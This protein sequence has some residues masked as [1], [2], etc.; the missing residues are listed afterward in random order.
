MATFQA[1]IEW[2]LQH[3]GGF[4]KAA[5]DPGNYYQGQLIGTNWGVSAPVAR[6]AGWTGRMEDM[7]RQWAIDNVYLPNYWP[8]LSAINNE[9]IA[10]KILDMRLSGKARADRYVQQGLI[11]MG[12]TISVD[13]VIGPMTAQAINQED[14]SVVMSMLQAQHAA[15]YQDSYDRNP[16]GESWLKN[17]MSRAA[18]VPALAVV[19][20]GVG[21]LGLALV[22]ML[23]WAAVKA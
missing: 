4:Q 20:G 23:V 19:A 1:A 9:N 22:G 15:I 12:W 14:A 6:S 10:A 18:D 13:G 21:L 5:S 3:E 11:D 16:I 2:V 7:P 17:W 8:G